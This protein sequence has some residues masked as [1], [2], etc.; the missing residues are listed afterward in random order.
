MSA[1]GD[2]MDVLLNR[3]MRELQKPGQNASLCAITPMPG[4]DVPYDYGQESCGGILWVRL[5]SANPSVS[6]PLSDVTVTNCASTLAYPLEVGIMRPAPLAEMVGD[7]LRLP[8]DAENAAAVEQQMLDLESMY[9]AIVGLGEDVENV[10]PGFY[11]PRGPEG[12]VVGGAWTLT[13]G[14]I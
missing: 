11:T 9:I 6:F 10:L 13:V 4:S 1:I 7:E 14:L 8:T 3:V 2:A 5:V 12:G